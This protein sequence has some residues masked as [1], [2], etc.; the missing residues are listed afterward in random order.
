MR[1]RAIDSENDWKF[2]KGRNDYKYDIS[3]VAQNLKTRI[4]S[5]LNDCF[6]HREAG[7]D[8]FNLLGSKNYLSLQLSINSTILNTEGVIAI[9]N[10]EQNIDSDRHYSVTYSVDTIFGN[11]TDTTTVEVTNA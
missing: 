9:T 1:V 3:A 4:Q 6:F 10:I 2:G 7:I 8:W 5:F 11:I